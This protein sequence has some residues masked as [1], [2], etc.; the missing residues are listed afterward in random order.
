MHTLHLAEN[1]K[2][3]APTSRQQIKVLNTK[4]IF[5][6]DVF[7]IHD[8][9]STD[10]ELFIKHGYLKQYNADIT[11]SMPWLLAINN[12]SLKA[13][14]GIRPAKQPLFIEQY[15]QQPIEQCISLHQQGIQREHIAEI[16]NLYSNSKAFTLPLFITTAISLFSNNYQYMV[17]AATDHV[18]TIMR[19]AGISDIFLAHATEEKLNPSNDSWGSYYQTKPQVIAVSLLDVIQTVHSNK[20]YAL[21][22]NQLNEKIAITANKLKMFSI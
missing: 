22:F 20:R 13:A 5:D 9:A 3:L 2:M 19:N 1:S 6:L 17:F 7:S 11:I 18:L 8:D 12:G 10:A 21:I 14:L 16:G 4:Y 15:L